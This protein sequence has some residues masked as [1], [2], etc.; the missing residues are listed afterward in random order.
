[1]AIQQ[2]KKMK[3]RTKK[4]RREVN[5]LVLTDTTERRRVLDR[6]QRGMF[7]HELNVSDDAFSRIFN[8]YVPKKRK[9]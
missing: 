5:H 9:K 8:E 1:M 2:K 7:V 6:R 3:R 4:D